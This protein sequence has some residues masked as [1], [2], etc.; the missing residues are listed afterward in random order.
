MKRY[1]VCAQED[2]QNDVFKQISES[3]YPN[4]RY[5]KYIAQEMWDARNYLIVRVEVVDRKLN[6]KRT[7]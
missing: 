2:V 3:S 5:A 1:I 6:V 7:K 4:K